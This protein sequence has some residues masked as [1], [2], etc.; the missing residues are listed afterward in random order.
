MA[1][2]IFI[3]YTKEDKA[4]ADGVVARLEGAN[5]RCWIAPRDIV[6]G[7]DWNESIMR[8]IDSCRA[9]VLV[10]TTAANASPDVRREVQAAFERGRVVIPVRADDVRPAGGLAYYLEGVHW[11]DAITPPWES[12]LAAVLSTVEKVLG[13]PADYPRV[14]GPTKPQHPRE[15]VSAQGAEGLRTKVAWAAAAVM[16]VI[17]GVVALV[18]ILPTRRVVEPF[19]APG[20]IDAKPPVQLDAPIDRS[21]NTGRYTGL[22]INTTRDVRGDMVL[23]I[24]SIERPH[25]RVRASVS[26]SG[27]LAGSAQLSGFLDSAGSMQLLGDVRQDNAQGPLVWRGELSCRFVD[28]NRV[29]GTYRMSPEVGNPYGTQEGTFAIQKSDSK[30]DRRSGC[31]RSV[32]T[33]YFTQLAIAFE[34]QCLT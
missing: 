28:P 8:A 20:R 22:A 23:L 4:L 3:S 17:L 2:D 1:H 32:A 21:T 12:H 14:S 9:L 10:F 27:G 7:S 19:S 15:V 18:S 29:E 34:G 5:V 13:S 16:A 31:D 30:V 33:F 6:G 24:T 25:G 26:W 11:L